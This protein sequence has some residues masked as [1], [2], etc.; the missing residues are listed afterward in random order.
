MPSRV[1][2]SVLDKEEGKGSS[3]AN[4]N[5]H[6]VASEA[7]RTAWV[8]LSL[9]WT[10]LKWVLSVEVFYRLLVALYHWDTP[11]SGAGWTFIAHFAVLTALTYFVSLYKPKGT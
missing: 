2:R 10:P 6:G 8:L 11:G 1:E 4:V 7:I 3:M 9:V 5:K